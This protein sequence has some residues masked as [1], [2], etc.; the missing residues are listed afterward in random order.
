MDS[1]Y[2]VGDGTASILY[3]IS[4]GVEFGP[5]A[6]CRVSEFTCLAAWATSGESSRYQRANSMFEHDLALPACSYDLD[7]FAAALETALVSTMGSGYVVERVGQ[8]ATGEAH[9]N[10]SGS[11]R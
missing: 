7:S 8:G 9:S 4:G 1:C 10:C 5:H 2:A 3:E 11:V 6:R